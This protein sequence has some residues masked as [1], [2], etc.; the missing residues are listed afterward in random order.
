SSRRRHT[1]FSRD[2][3]SDVCSSDLCDRGKHA[4]LASPACQETLSR[5]LAEDHGMR[6]IDAQ[7]LQRAIIVGLQLLLSAKEPR[8]H[9]D[10]LEASKRLISARQRGVEARGIR[11]V[12]RDRGDLATVSGANL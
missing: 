6:E 8:G 11:K 3:S 2:W 10:G 7:Q 1:R 4:K 5:R 9:H 12:A